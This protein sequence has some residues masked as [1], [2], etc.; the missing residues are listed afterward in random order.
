MK[1]PTYI[2]GSDHAGYKLKEFVKK[3][4]LEK[5][6]IVRDL[7][8]YDDSR[9]DYP[10]YGEKVGLRLAKTKNS[11]GFLTCGTGI[12]LSISANKIPGIRA[13][14][15]NSPNDAKMAREHNDANVLV[16]AGRPFNRNNVKKILDV[17]L[18]TKFGGGRHLKRVN[19]VKR[20][21]KKYR[22]S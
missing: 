5:K 11:M 7:G 19:K 12:G 9:V 10:D 16:L 1:T 14:L 18:K 2:L 13:A 6:I 15:V 3:I 17:W 4:L 22:K 20:L 8:P 21:D